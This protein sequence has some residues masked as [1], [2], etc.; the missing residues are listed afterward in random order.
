MIEDTNRHIDAH[1]EAVRNT[2]TDKFVKNLHELADT[3]SKQLAQ[4]S[5]IMLF[6]NGG[7]AADSQHIAAEFVS[8][9]QQDRN[10]LPAIALTTDTSILT[11]IG[12]DYG[13]EHT[14]AR[15]ISAL[16]KKGDVAVGIT[17]SG[18]SQ[19]VIN[20][21]K[22]AQEIGMTAVALTGCNGLADKTVSKTLRV[23]SRDTAII[24]ELHIMIG[25]LICKQ[26]EKQFL[27]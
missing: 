15:Q 25:H 8:K 4:G 17:T 5:K 1:V 20:G 24:Q 2:F 14:F 18:N 12:N 11:A 7:S 10:P 3:I 22:C 23:Q 9:L 16:G 27:G 21:L 26:S 13:F 19:N 6:G